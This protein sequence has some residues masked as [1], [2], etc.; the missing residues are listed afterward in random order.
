MIPGSSFIGQAV[1]GDAPVGNNPSLL[2][3]LA[4]NG[5]GFIASS[6]LGAVGF[7]LLAF[8]TYYLYLVTKRR[9][10]DLIKAVLVLGLAGPLLFAV[11]SVI[12]PIYLVSEANSYSELAAQSIQ[13]AKEIL[14]TGGV[15]QAIR[16]IGS[17]A[18]LAIGLWF[19]IGSLYAM[20]VGL[21][22]RAI[23]I[24]G[25]VIGA[26]FVLGAT[27]TP[28][29]LA[30]WLLALAALFF[31]AWPGGRPPAWDSGTAIPWQKLGQPAVES[32]AESQ[33]NE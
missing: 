4:D 7:L 21:L 33:T 27:F 28:I 32:A 15:S 25:I 5:A 8:V 12:Q 17:A 18:T 29:V 24:V 31:G 9:K 30:L 19:V 13:R 14:F 6:A 10:P 23:G 20:R 3:F 26:A 1:I 11:V 2:R 22:T 16:A